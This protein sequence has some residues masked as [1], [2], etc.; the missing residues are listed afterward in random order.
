MAIFL[1]CA[2]LK[3]K[4][5]SKLAIKKKKNLQNFSS[6]QLWPSSILSWF[7]VLRVMGKKECKKEDRDEEQRPWKGGWELEKQQKI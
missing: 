3:Y 7:C 2:Y 1:A 5:N 4:N 6:Y